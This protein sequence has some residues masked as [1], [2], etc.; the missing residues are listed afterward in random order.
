[1]TSAGPQIAFFR[2]CRASAVPTPSARI[3]A[4]K[5]TNRSAELLRLALGPA[6][7][8]G[9][10]ITLS[11]SNRRAR[12]LR[13]HT[14]A[15]MRCLR[16]ACLAIVVLS[17]IAADAPAQEDGVF[18][19]PDSPAGKEYAIPFDEARR[20][21]GGGSGGGPRTAA[22]FGEG[23]TPE[24]GEA[25][26]RREDASG[27]GDRDGREI[28][29]GRTSPASPGGSPGVAASLEQG[30]PSAALLAGGIALG[31]LLLG[32]TIGLVVRRTSR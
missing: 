15:S 29:G 25:P 5:P 24:D 22:P 9:G 19:D 28:G 17:L 13:W 11:Y 14:A 3:S 20:E 31:V 16:Q 23:I 6:R 8:G 21:A 7:L 2:D 1:M 30:G 27:S 26:A 32:A 18:V 12:E 10:R 4:R